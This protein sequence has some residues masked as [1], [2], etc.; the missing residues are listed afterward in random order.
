[1]QRRVETGSGSLNLALNTIYM[2][3]ERGELNRS[4]EDAIAEVQ[5]L[6][7]EVS[8][9]TSKKFIENGTCMDSPKVCL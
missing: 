2:R 4:L 8:I 6:C 1:M 9:R 7:Q 3:D 5:S